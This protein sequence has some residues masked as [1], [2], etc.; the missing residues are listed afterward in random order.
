MKNFT[1]F[2]SYFTDYIDGSELGLTEDYNV[3][4]ELFQQGII[5]S[6]LE[7]HLF[8]I[9]DDVKR[10]LSMTKTPN[11]NDIVKA[12][13]RTIFLDV[14]FKKEEMAKLGI[15]LGYDEIIG[16]MVSEGFVV[17][18]Q[19]GMEEQKLV[20]LEM[21]KVG[22]DLRITICSFRKETGKE[23]W[24]DVFTENVNIN[25]EY[26]S[27]GFQVTRCD[28]TDQN[29]RKFIHLFVLNFLNFLNDPEV[30]LV[31]VE[32]DE[33]RNVKRLHKGKLPIPER[34]IIRITGKMKIYLDELRKNPVWHY[35]Y[36]FWVR[37]HF[38][39]LRNERYGENVGR[40]KWIFPYIKGKGLLVESIYK[41]GKLD[42]DIDE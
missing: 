13:F 17:V 10:L 24:F 8:E 29:A 33:V 26:Q 21:Q 38:R 22:S 18:K 16:I 39:T 20:D 27:H 14:G 6:I 11:Q 12:P 34:K 31:T 25:P 41:I 7:C 30:S 23:L 2:T 1:R 3:S 42:G 19:D 15:K 36:R 5:N 40:R 32:R 37:G 4:G 9:S 35:H 28:H